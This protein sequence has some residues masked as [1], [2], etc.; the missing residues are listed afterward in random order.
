[1]FQIWACKQVTEIASTNANI[2]EYDK[3]HSPYCPSCNR[4]V[5]TCSHVLRCRDEGRVAALQ[6]S[7]G[8]MNKWLR[9]VGTDPRL[10]QCIIQYARGRGGTTLEH[11]AR[12]FGSSYQHLATSQDKIGWRR[13]MEGMISKEM[14]SIQESFLTKCNSTWTIETWTKGLVVKLLETTHGQ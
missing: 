9:S 3:D 11:I 2:A 7:I 13:F 5:E 8:L 6:H 4:A 10:R 12:P 14:V 1:M